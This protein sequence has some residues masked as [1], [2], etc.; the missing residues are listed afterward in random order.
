MPLRKDN[1]IRCRT[2]RD[3]KNSS[4]HLSN[5]RFVELLVFAVLFC[6][7]YAD[8][9]N[10]AYVCNLIQFLWITSFVYNSV[11]LYFN[12]FQNFVAY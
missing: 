1:R 12:L 11:Y 3:L 5:E 10:C 6:I 2:K 9:K 7:L 4:R 8:F